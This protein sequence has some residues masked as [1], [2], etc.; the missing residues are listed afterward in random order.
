MSA[1]CG[2]GN[3]EYR[4]QVRANSRANGGVCLRQQISPCDRF[5]VLELI[6]KRETAMSVT[7]ALVG[8]GDGIPLEHPT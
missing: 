7:S 6:S 1:G 3:L 5:A 8:G 2:S 4:S